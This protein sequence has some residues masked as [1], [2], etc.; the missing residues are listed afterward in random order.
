MDANGDS[1]DKHF[2]TFMRENDLHDVVEYHSPN[3]KDQNTYINGKN[4]LDYVLA[5]EELLGPGNSVGH[6][7][8]SHPFVS[9]HREVYWDVAV[10]DLFDSNNLSPKNVGQRGLQLERSKQVEEYVTQLVILCSRHRILHRAQTLETKMLNTTDTAT[11]TAMY[12]KFSALDIERV[13]Y[14]KRAEAMCNK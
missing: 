4:Q 9:D 5:S 14:M 13:R 8:F 1:S 11:L 2:L 12:T 7:C 6:T 10:R 3:A